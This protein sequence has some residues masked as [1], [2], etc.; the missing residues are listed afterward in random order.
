MTNANAR[1]VGPS[2]AAAALYTAF[3][4][5]TNAPGSGCRRAVA[6]AGR[7]A[8]E[9]VFGNTYIKIIFL[10]WF[11]HDANDLQNSPASIFCVN[12]M[13]VTTTIDFKKR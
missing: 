12:Y 13:D 3:H 6:L 9:D 1:L 11:S 2:T 8:R 5:S 4:W 10:E 7:A